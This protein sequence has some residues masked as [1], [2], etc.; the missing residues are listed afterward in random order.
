MRGIVPDYSTLTRRHVKVDSICSVCKTTSETLLH[1]LAE[2][3]HARLFWTEAK[4]ILNVKLPNLHPVTW[5]ADI[6]AEDWWSPEERAKVITVMWSIWSSRNRWTHGERGFDPGIAIKAVRDTLLELELPQAAVTPSRKQ[7]IC[8]WQR[9]IAG[10]VKINVDGAFNSQENVAGSGGVAREG[11]G[12]F[13]GAWCKAYPGIVDPLVAETLALRDA[14]VFAQ[15]RNFSRIVVETDCSELVRLWESRTRN[16]PMITPLLEE[17]SMLSFGFQIFSI[18][19]ARRSANN[20][21]HACARYACLNNV[22]E[23]WIEASPVFLQNSLYADC[24]GCVLN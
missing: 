15:T 21:A 13:R 7:Q 1:A 6:L 18:S 14:V 3:S 11:A 9:P 2:C 16:R 4:N 8:T 22:D 24:N 12:I 23:N 20:S 5:A 19:F 10:V 17:V